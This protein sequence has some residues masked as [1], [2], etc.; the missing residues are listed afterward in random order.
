D[1]RAVCA[2][3]PDAQ[4]DLLRHRPAGQKD[5]RFLAEQ[6]RDLALEVLDE[7]ALAIEIRIG[8]L[9]ARARKLGQRLRGTSR[10][11]PGDAALAGEGG[12]SGCGG[13]ES[14][15]TA[16]MSDTR[17]AHNDAPESAPAQ[18]SAAE[19]AA[20]GDGAL[21]DALADALAPFAWPAEPPILPRYGGAAVG[22]AQ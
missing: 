20:A 3:A 14:G 5:R 16:R 19:P 18:A 10:P 15:G 13:D 21:A 7:R 17:N 1:G 8:N 22:A 4:R 11:V 12:G 2:L 9:G 6:L